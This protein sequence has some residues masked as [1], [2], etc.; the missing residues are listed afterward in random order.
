MDNGSVV[1]TSSDFMTSDGETIHFTSARDVAEYAVVSSEAHKAFVRQLFQ[2]LIKQPANAYGPET[3]EKLRTSFEQSKFQ[4]PET[5]LRN[6]P[7]R[8]A[9]GNR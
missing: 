3:L 8:C 9:P 7:N 6:R 1:D 5:R 4:R 2:Q